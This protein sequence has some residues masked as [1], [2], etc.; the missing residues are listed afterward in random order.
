MKI[1]DR[2]IGDGSPPFIISEIGINHGGSLEV[3]KKMVKTIAESGGECVKHQT[4]ILEDE[5]TEEAKA[6][7]PPNASI[8]IWEIMEKCCLS[9]DEEYE[10]KEFSEK[11]GLIYLSTPFSR[12]AADFLNEIGVLAFK[13][14][15]GEVDNLALLNHIANFK[16]PMIVSTGM[17]NLQDLD[18]SVSLLKSKE[19]EFA[20]LECTNLYPSQPE[21]VS[22]N[23]ITELRDRYQVSV[24]FSDHSIGPYMAIASISKGACII[25]RHFTDTRYREGPDIICSMDGPEL[26]LLVDISKEIALSCNNKKERT[27]PEESVRLFARSSL[28]ADRDIKKGEVLDETMVWARRPGN[29][30]ISGSEY[31]SVIGK[32]VR[33]DLKYNH[34]LQWEDLI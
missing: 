27:S 24:G 13:V 11:L 6:I 25:E 2:E 7:I 33:R 20:L 32:K 17:Q 14:G 4:H 31:F 1:G 21:F 19:V 3:A 30:E 16:K 10:L 12:K 15:S 23:G 29:G 34:Q 18:R 26:R 22:L 8:S 9:L 28:V 5:M